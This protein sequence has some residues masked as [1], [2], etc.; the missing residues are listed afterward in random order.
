MDYKRKG[1]AKLWVYDKDTGELY[2][3]DDELYHYG[4]KGMKWGQNIFGKVTAT[5]GRAGKFIGKKI[6]TSARDARNTYRHKR[7]RRKYQKES[8]ALRKKP[9]NKMTSEELDSYIKRLYKEKE[10]NDLRKSL[11]NIDQKN[12]SAGKKF[13]S[14][15]Y[16]KLLKQPLLSAG[17][18]AL[19]KLFTKKLNEKLGIDIEDKSNS[20]DLLKKGIDK[21]TDSEIN[22][23]SKRADSTSNIQKILLGM[24]TNDNEDR[25]D[26][27]NSRSL[28]NRP[29]KDLTDSELGKAK[30]RA[31]NEDAVNKFIKKQSDS[32]VSNLNEDTIETA[33]DWMTDN[34]DS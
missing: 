24:K 10:A 15:A 19:T 26:G 5:A 32:T 34:W 30:K 4:R 29:L 20:M 9:L 18:T 13:I 17:N 7:D 2:H 28:F 14:D 6:K 12:V 25:D 11:S 21:L 22:K 23:L 3:Y 31:D 33:I 27:T 8:D 16:D 1:V